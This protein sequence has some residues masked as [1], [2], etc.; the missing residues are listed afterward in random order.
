MCDS[1]HLCNKTGPVDIEG[2]FTL[3]DV[4]GREDW[5]SGL[6]YGR[7]KGFFSRGKGPHKKITTVSQCLQASL[8][9]LTASMGFELVDMVRGMLASDLLALPTELSLR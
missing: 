8:A 4:L 3:W 9:A 7:Y 1:D 6:E 2:S 5:A